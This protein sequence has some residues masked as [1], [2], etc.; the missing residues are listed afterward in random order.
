MRKN[1]TMRLAAL[2]L[3]LTLITSCF[4]G[5]TFAK[6]TSTADNGTGDVVKVA[7]WEIIYKVGDNEVD[8][9]ENETISFD[10]FNTILDTK[11]SNAEGDVSENLIAPGTKGSFALSVQNKSEV[12]AEYE[13]TLAAAEAN[14]DIPIKYSLDQTDWKDDIADL[15]LS[16]TL[17]IGAVADPYTVYWQWVYTGGTDA[18]DEKDTDLGIA[19]QDT[20][21]VP[22]ITVTASITATQVD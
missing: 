11:D 21:K 2:L 7:K 17:E 3:V 8:I 10:L 15:E 13:I 4:V 5:G 18:L 1:K 9:A 6:Y 19:A 14:G 12:T 22:S 16:N 20:T